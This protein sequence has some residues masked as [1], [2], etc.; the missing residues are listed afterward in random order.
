MGLVLHYDDPA[1]VV[2]FGWNGL[3]EALRPRRVAALIEPVAYD[4]PW[5]ASTDDRLE[6]LSR[7]ERGWDGYASEP[8]KRTVIAFARSVLNSVMAPNT[9]APTIVPMGGG[10]L[11][12]E[13]HTGGLDVELAIYRPREAEL[14]V[15]FADG[16]DPIE[17]QP[18]ASSFDRLSEVLEEL[19]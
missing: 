9:P 18:L 3:R 16:R 11:Q 10:G 17:E 4:E 6:R 7:Y 15:E 13:W 2:D 12:L 8:P 1:P 14:S 19:A 5:R